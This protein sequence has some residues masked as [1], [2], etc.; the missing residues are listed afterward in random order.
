M[1]VEDAPKYAFRAVKVDGTRSWTPMAGMR[2]VVDLCAWGK[3]NVLHWVLA[4]P[5]EVSTSIDVLQ[6]DKVDNIAT[7][8]H[9]YTDEQVRNIIQYAYQRGVRILIEF[10]LD[11]RMSILDLVQ[12]EETPVHSNPTHELLGI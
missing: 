7:T 2:H 12:G 9:S 6:G 3:L 10:E 1:V 4:T 8:P 11:P 5:D